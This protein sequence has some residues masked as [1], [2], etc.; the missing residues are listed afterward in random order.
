M[1]VSRTFLAASFSYPYATWNI[2][3]VHTYMHTYIHAYIHT[4]HG[5]LFSELTLHY[6]MHTEI[7]PLRLTFLQAACSCADQHDSQH[8][9]TCSFRLRMHVTHTHTHTNTHTHT[10]T[11][12]HTWMHIFSIQLSP[13]ERAQRS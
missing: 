11:Y 3:I 12:I 9:K 10:H 1:G 5:S 4:Y 2:I 8:H 13:P 6:N 7:L